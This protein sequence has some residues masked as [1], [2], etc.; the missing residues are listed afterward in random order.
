METLILIL[1][2]IPAIMVALYGDMEL[3]TTSQLAVTVGIPV[4]TIIVSVFIS[5]R[6][7]NEKVKFAQ[8][9][10]SKEHTSL[11]KNLSHDIALSYNNLSGKLDTIDR[12]I[13]NEIITRKNVTND[14]TGIFEAAELI[15]SSV[16]NILSENAKLTEE[17]FLLKEQISQLTDE[18]SKLR[19]ELDELY[20]SEDDYS[21]EK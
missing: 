1:G 10:L 16:D 2:Y 21:H 11:E 19:N 15:K 4:L 8:N 3:D 9:D 20:S 6:S 7:G 18:N 17:N 12:I 13:N 14:K 5:I